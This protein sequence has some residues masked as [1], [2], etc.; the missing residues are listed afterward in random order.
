[1][2]QNCPTPKSL[3]EFGLDVAGFSR[4][5][6]QDVLPGLSPAPPYMKAPPSSPSLQA[7]PAPMAAP[8]LAATTPTAT[9]TTATTHTTTTT[10]PGR[11]AA[12]RVTAQEILPG[13]RAADAM[14]EEEAAACIM[15]NDRAQGKQAFSLMRPQDLA[16]RLLPA[17]LAQQLFQ[18]ASHG[19]PADCGP[20][21]PQDVVDLAKTIGPHKS[22]LS[23]E[24]AALV[25]EDVSYQQSAGFGRI[26][27]ESEL[28][29]DGGPSNLKI[30]RVAVVPQTGRRGRIILNLSS[31]VPLP[32][33]REPGKRR[34]RTRV[35]PSVNATLVLAKDQAGVKALG[36]AMHAILLFCALREFW[37]QILLEMLL[38]QLLNLLRLP[39]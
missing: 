25:W 18:F 4:Q 22:A 26:V 12:T 5:R 27:A 36:T 17:Q 14:S 11:P 32:A 3:S 16:L 24:S 9:T 30:S 10:T 31:E 35:H 28:F 21:W 8:T 33:V 38:L 20:P 13:F 34:K 7:P 2:R 15:P 37:L 1:M 29:A 39:R 19:C 6:A 23:P